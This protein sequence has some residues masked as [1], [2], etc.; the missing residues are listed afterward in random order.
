MVADLDQ[1]VAFYKAIGFSQDRAAD[2][3]WRKDKDP[4]HLV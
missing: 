4:R 1:S 3:A 2:T